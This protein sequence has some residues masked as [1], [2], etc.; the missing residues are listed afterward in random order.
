MQHRNTGCGKS[1]R[2]DDTKARMRF[3]I[4]QIKVPE[5]IEKK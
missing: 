2:L 5:R 1:E 4:Q 3:S